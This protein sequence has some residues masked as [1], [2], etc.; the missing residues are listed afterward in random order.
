MNGRGVVVVV[1][2]LLALAGCGRGVPAQAGPTGTVHGLI[3]LSGGPRGASDEPTAGTVVLSR[4]GSQVHRQDVAAGEPYSFS[5]AAGA[6]VLTVKG[7]SGA[8]APE[9]ITVS[10][11]ADLKHDLFCAIK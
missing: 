9:T 10:A 2:G 5:V 4:D 11:N 8:C 1:A 3:M 7:V 6:Y